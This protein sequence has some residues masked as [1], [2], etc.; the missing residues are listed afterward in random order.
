MRAW[1]FAAILLFASSAAAQDAV[2]IAG[3]RIGMTIDEARAVDPEII[4]PYNEG[5]QSFHV[6]RGGHSVG[7]LNTPLQLIFLNGTLDFVGSEDT[8]QVVSSEA[9][10]ERLQSVVAA[11]ES[12]AHALDDAEDNA[13][14]A[15]ARPSLRTSGGS[16]IRV[17][18]SHG[19]TSTVAMAYAPIYAEVRSYAHPAA[20]SAR[21]CTVSYE[22][23]S[24]APPP[25]D[26]PRGSLQNI[27]W[28]E[29]PDGR[30]FARFYPSRAMELS[31]PGGTVLFCTVLTDGSLDCAVAYE[32]PQ[33]WGFGQSAL[34]IA[35]AFR[36]APQTEDGV[37]T[38]GQTVRVPIRFR[39]SF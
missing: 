26:L 25:T 35:R 23:S 10:I 22:L 9:C 21:H 6:E 24:Q 14:S 11:L 17:S 29:R 38:A 19:A 16:I 36:A 28:A 4:Q 2:H 3:F 30:N 20:A 8:T 5:L 12:G 7:D 18:E 31:R 39:V 13:A 37:A 1:L 33:G 34:R 15:S 27:P 32:G